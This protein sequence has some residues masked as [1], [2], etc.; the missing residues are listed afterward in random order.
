MFNK[1]EIM[2]KAW[3]IVKKGPNW[4][5]YRLIRLKYALQEAWAEAKRAAKAAAQTAADTLR[6][7]LL[8]LEC[9]DRWTQADYAA[10]AD[11]R[12]RLH[13]AEAPALPMAA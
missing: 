6:E 7:A 4:Q 1:S 13:L 3:A 11:L 10:A 2:R 5:A 8:M 12:A 9:K